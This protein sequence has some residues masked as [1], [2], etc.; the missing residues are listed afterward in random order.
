MANAKNADSTR[1]LESGDVY[2]FY[3]PKV[4][5]DE[6]HGIGDVEH[7]HIVFKPEDRHLYRMVSIGRK[8]LPDVERHERNW[9][10]VEKVARSADEIRRDLA[11]QHYETKT[12]GERTRPAARPAGEGVYA[13]VQTGRNMHLVYALEL[14]KRPGPVQDALGIDGEAS[15]AVSIK[16]PERA[17]PPGV[18]LPEEKKADYPESK[19]AEFGPRRFAPSD[20]TLLDYEGAEF[21]L[22]GARRN[23]EQAYGVELETEPENLNTAEIV[24]DLRLRREQRP[25]E[26]LLKGEWA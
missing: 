26:P 5:H 20:P 4:Q 11:E 12:R 13:F 24:K 10:F 1:I 22:V 18:G 16:N 19:Q 7:L 2:F 15:F 3:R 23:P 21:L 8:R 6:A 17:A 14:P 9:G 25:L